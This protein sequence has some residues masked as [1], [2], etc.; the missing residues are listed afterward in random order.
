MNTYTFAA[1]TYFKGNITPYSR[2]QAELLENQKD[3]YS[4]TK[5]DVIKLYYPIE[6]YH[7]IEDNESKAILED[8]LGYFLQ[9]CL[10]DSLEAWIPAEGDLLVY[11]DG[12]VLYRIDIEGYYN[13]EW[14]IEC[15]AEGLMH[16]DTE[17]DFI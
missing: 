10:D 5:I 14:E 12:T 7:N 2:L 3:F 4:D 1:Y 16:V 11:K 17:A 15:E 8:L 6:Y 13:D 9:E